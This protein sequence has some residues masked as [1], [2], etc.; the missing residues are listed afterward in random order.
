M[1]HRPI[2]GKT[3][4]HPLRSLLAVTAFLTACGHQDTF[5]SGEVPQAGPPSVTPPVRLTYAAGEDLDPVW[6]ADGLDLIYSFRKETAGGVDRCLGEIPGDGGTR[7]LEKCVN[8]GP[9]QDSI[10]ALGPVAV[11]PG[12][13]AAWMDF[14]GL[15]GRT[16]PDAGSLRIG[17]LAAL[18]SG[19][20]VHTF[21]YPAPS[22]QLHAT[23]TNLSWLASNLLAYIGADVFYVRPCM[24]CKMDTVVISREAVIAGLGSSP[25]TLQTIPNTA[26][27]TSLFPSADG[28]SIYYTRPGDSR[29]YQQVLSSG[30]ES[31]IHDFGL[32][33]IARDVNIRGNVLTATVGGNVDFRNDPLLGPRQVD[34]GGVLY[35]VDLT[36]GDELSL[37]ISNGWTRHPALSPDGRSVVVEA[38]DTLIPPPRT[39]LWLFRLP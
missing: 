12:S 10:M 3:G 31:T 7:F 28:L 15:T 35:R 5:G 26:Q 18:D 2:S 4:V 38:T 6:T 8:S 29:V 24:G 17:S 34:S 32:A 21:P 27:I 36:T 25:A 13:L 14:R 22:G 19:R 9:D 33:G 37:P 1:L 11:G 23:A 20:T 30:A 39:D 16:A